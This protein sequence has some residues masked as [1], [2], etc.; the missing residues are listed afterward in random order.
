MSLNFL[1]R[2]KVDQL[3]QSQTDAEHKALPAI[4]APPAQPKAGQRERG[5]AAGGETKM[6]DDLQAIADLIGQL[7]D[8]PPEPE[9]SAPRA[10]AVVEPKAEKLPP[11][12][13][14]V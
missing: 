4:A 8:D 3:P 2:G 11:E 9:P 14:A 12:K 6:T 1:V 5:L 10:L 13:F 7:S